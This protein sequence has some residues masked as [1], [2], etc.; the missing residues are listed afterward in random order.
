MASSGCLTARTTRRL[1]LSIEAA[2]IVSAFVVG[3]YVQLLPAGAETRFSRQHDAVLSA[4]VL[5]LYLAVSIPVGQVMC[6]RLERRADKAAARGDTDPVLGLP[7]A[8]ARQSFLMWLGA[9]AIFGTLNW[10]FDPSG[11][12][13]AHVVA[14]ILLGACTTVGLVYLL[15]EREMRPL[16]AQV[17]AGRAPDSSCGVLGVRRRLLLSWALGSGVVLLG[18]LLTPFGLT[19]Q[20][21]GAVTS[22]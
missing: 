2:N 12:Q 13:T 3:C 21:R 16:Y 1:S 20:Q 17:L 6:R 22:R 19:A 4:I 11:F 7:A 8:Y 18:V 14:G 9:A 10:W 5:L 15:T